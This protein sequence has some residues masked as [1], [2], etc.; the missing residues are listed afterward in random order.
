MAITDSLKEIQQMID[1]LDAAKQAATAP[2]PVPPT[3][4]CSPVAPVAPVA[5][6]QQPHDEPHDVFP[7]K[8]PQFPQELKALNRWIVRTADKRPFSPYEGDENLG[9]IN[10][11]DEQYQAG[12]NC[13]MGALD[14]LTMFSG[15]G[16]VF[17][18]A[19]GYTGTDFDHCVNP[20]TLEIRADVREIIEK[21]DSYAEFSPSRSGVHV[22]TKGWQFPIGA[23]GEQGTKVGN[24]EMYSGKRYFTVTGAHVP[25]TPLTVNSRDLGW[26]Y[27]RIVV[28]REFFVAKHKAGAAGTS[29]VTSAESSCAVT[30]K[31]PGII[32]SKYDT[33]MFGTI[34]RS[35]DTT[36]SSDVAIEDAAQI[37]E[38]E[39]QNSADYALLRLIA[40][41]LNTTD[42]EAIKDEFLKSPLG[43]R[44]K[45]NRDGYLDNSIQ[46]LLKEPRR[47]FVRSA[48]DVDGEL[49]GVSV[50][51]PKLNTEVGNARRLIETYG[52][53]IRYCP[54][55][56]CW[57]YFNGKVWIVDRH[58]VHVH[59]LM[60][61]V[62]I[63]M[64]QEASTAEDKA[65]PGPE[66]MAKLNKDFTPKT[67]TVPLTEEELKE[68]QKIGSKSKFKKV[69]ATLT[70]EER[71][72]L[73]VVQDCKA[74][75]TWA[76]ESESSSRIRGSVEQA[77]SE[78]GVSIAKSILDMNVM[79]C[80]VQ[81]GRFLF[82]V[83]GD[84]LF[85][86]HLR[87]DYCT[88]MMPVSYDPSAVCPQFT[89]FLEWMFPEEGVRTFIQTYSGLCLTG[90]VPRKALILYGEGSN[91]KSTLAAVLKHM[92]DDVIDH[93]GALIGRSYHQSA[94]F[95]TFTVGKHGGSAGGT[96]ADIVGLKGAR[97]IVSAESNK[98]SSK[99]VV[100]LDMARI[101]EFTGNDET[102]VR[103]LYQAE[104]TKF[105]NQ[106]KLI[107]HTNNLPTINDDSNGAWD[108]I[109]PVECGS[110]VA[111]EDQDPNL[112]GKLTSEA[113]GILNWLLEG[114]AMYFRQGLIAT[115]SM[116]V[117]KDA[118]R[119][120]ENHMGR[121]V[122][123]ECEIV[124]Q[125]TTRTASSEVYECYRAWCGRHGEQ[126]D[127]QK[128]L[129]LHLKR[130]H[131]VDNLSMR[132]SVYLTRVR[133]KNP[134]PAQGGGMVVL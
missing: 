91:G 114:L 99:Q 29:T 76:K 32:S 118:Y 25:G 2:T 124:A 134:N 82:D 9:T 129:T 87:S 111:E 92:F 48:T 7:D 60:K 4:T 102:K 67:V 22:I 42:V 75:L 37:L 17:N 101:K 19:D 88:K 74:F 103:G 116:D 63:L 5:A 51:R 47:P 15:A 123:E 66:L 10:P 125:D 24:A 85:G 36:G 21:M 28:K 34:L 105:V 94:A 12:Y 122:L 79:A 38:Y 62:L 71:N 41:K 44:S 58:E 130:K 117:S 73:V 110:S 20:E 109:T 84:V 72:M 106:G 68:A 104:E 14:Q 53:N 98:S 59:D 27:Q 26:L 35:K 119:G 1:G 70:N 93:S 49:T 3:A 132:D 112:P 13:A 18:Y 39:S 107:L 115:E 11:H 40:D 54:E 133:L 33:L 43:Q 52:K 57:L 55:D 8:A 131:K 46:K 56:N 121:F 96:R 6:V 97:L 83:T 80:N 128:D 90:I 16:F 78:P 69:E 30:L 100:K 86:K 95:S 64:Q 81:N 127:S 61:R 45:A 31:Q 120:S 50:D 113:S 126:P 23:G 65:S 108:R 77:R 89:K